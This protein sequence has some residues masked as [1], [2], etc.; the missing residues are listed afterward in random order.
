M[1]YGGS[2]SYSA[3]Y[4][5][6]SSSVSPIGSSYSA[7][8]LNPGGNF[9]THSSLS[10]Y[11]RP[12]LSGR[13]VTSS[14]RNYAPLLS[15]ISERGAA[16]PVRIGS[17]RRLQITSRPYTT[18]SYTPRPI[19]INTADIDVSRDRYRN[20]AESETP[21]PSSPE[22]E[23][24][25]GPFMPRVDGKSETGIDSSLGLQRSTIKRGRT[26]VRLHTVKR[27]DKE[28]PRKLQLALSQEENS[29]NLNDIDSG[30]AAKENIVQDEV[31]P[32]RW[33]DKLSEDLIYKEKREKKSLG[34][35]LKEKFI[36]KDKDDEYTPP[37]KKFQSKQENSSDLPLLPL[38]TTSSSLSRSPDRRCSIEMLAEQANLL[39]SLI[40]G[41]N[42]STATL[43][44]SKVG[45]SDENKSNFEGLPSVNKRKSNNT[46]NPLQ[47]T[48]SDHSLHESMKSFKDHKESKQFSKRRSLKKSSSGGSICRLDS[49]TEFP[50]ELPSIEES[51]LSIKRDSVKA[52]PKPKVK[53]I[54]T[55]SSVEVSEPKSP[56]KFKVEGVTVEE[57]PRTLK[58]EISF[59]SV[60]E[61]QPKLDRIEV[62][63]EIGNKYKKKDNSLADSTQ[64]SNVI[65][66]E[67]DDGNFW[68]KIGKRETIYLRKRREFLEDSREQN[69]RAFFWF[70]EEDESGPN[71]D[72]EN[73]NTGATYFMAEC[74][75][76]VVSRGKPISNDEI[77]DNP[78]TKA[79]ECAQKISKAEKDESKEDV[80]MVSTVSD[81]NNILENL[82]NNEVNDV[83][84]ELDN[85]HEQPPRSNN[86]AEQKN[87][88]T[89]VQHIETTTKSK[90]VL[91]TK[92]KI[93]KNITKPIKSI[94]NQEEC[95]QDHEDAKPG[96]N[97]IT[98]PISAIK[99]KKESE[100]VHEQ[101]KPNIHQNV[102]EPVCPKN[103]KID[104]KDNF[105]ELKPIQ[106][107]V[108]KMTNIEK[109]KIEFRDVYDETKPKQDVT[110]PRNSD[111]NKSESK[112]ICEGVKPVQDKVTLPTNVIK[113]KIE[114]K[115]DSE[116]TKLI[117][118]D[119]VTKQ[120]NEIKDKIES[121][122]KVET[123]KPK[124]QENLTKS[125]K[126]EKIETKIALGRKENTEKVL[127][128]QNTFEK[129]S[130][131]KIK[132][133][134]TDA[135]KVKDKDKNK[136][137]AGDIETKIHKDYDDETNKIGSSKEM[138]TEKSITDEVCTECGKLMDPVSSSTKET[139]PIAN[140]GSQDIVKVPS[141]EETRIHSDK[142]KS[143]SNTPLPKNNARPI[144]KIQLSKDVEKPSTPK[145]VV[146][147]V[148]KPIS[149][150][151]DESNED[152]LDDSKQNKEE[153]NQKSLPYVPSTQILVQS[154]NIP[155]SENDAKVDP[156]H[157]QKTEEGEDRKA[158]NDSQNEKNKEIM[159]Q[160][161]SAPVVKLPR[162]PVKDE[163]ALRPLIA[164]P[165]PLL[166]R[167]PQVIHLS[168]SSESSSEEEESSDDDDDADESDTS[169][170]SAEFFECENN[171][172]GRTSTGS[173]DSGFDSSAPTSPSN[174]SSIKKGKNAIIHFCKLGIGNTTHHHTNNDRSI[175]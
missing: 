163:P 162:R 174:F 33:R 143:A 24:D 9:S 136:V 44:L 156:L 28:S 2:S 30:A 95:K 43:D 142:M 84:T 160:P 123:T 135:Q 53:A 78:L 48:K 157:E 106:D 99:N 115:D 55:S 25:K 47:T 130:S 71:D 74:E 125:A 161:I 127:P 4:S 35:K 100:D 13:W 10:G 61:E 152:K 60:V 51:R 148:N 132:E 41:E 145:E 70:P 14:G 131:S 104:S 147:S 102:T 146:S 159:E 15:T 82:I 40:R 128:K 5:S 122:D 3:P 56:L 32:K 85:P 105:E 7:S 114:S 79:E 75:D 116:E 111:K 54:I 69:R 26:V 39:D 88:E 65:S 49:I 154:E 29:T 158:E 166:K 16:G 1:Y 81:D 129:K 120:I 165:R 108:P 72:A 98:K 59:T 113:N 121:K 23:N 164:T 124:I 149:I 101:T 77:K 118:Q 17:P 20:K 134:P 153:T 93:Q 62:A 31:E 34:E 175:C 171:A 96:Q 139:I 151:R 169:E 90:V 58:K 45:L 94:K 66:P 167:T 50:R 172:D 38:T 12:P 140:S 46:E 119:N 168:S 87:N 21:P 173:N 68:D 170:D 8:Y 103:D 150:E 144:N 109:N 63:P 27:K 155:K 57:K 18:P 19:N 6:Y 11:S 97:T 73:I 42:L 110:K 117:I 86:T 89:E 91:E 133:K 67:P 92:S 107:Y 22:P 80:I 126:K 36:L 83:T 141:P 137:K 138:V 52:K 37:V 64:N 76:H 112:N